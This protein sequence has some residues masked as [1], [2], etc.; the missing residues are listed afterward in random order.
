M[1][2][3]PL[4]RILITS[5]LKNQKTESIVFDNPLPSPTIST[6][7][8]EDQ[9]NESALTPVSE[10]QNEETE[11]KP[12]H[13]IEN[14]TYDYLPQGKIFTYYLYFFYLCYVSVI[15][16]ILAFSNVLSRL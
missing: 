6:L 5:L 7:E 10:V 3:Q 9:I 12:K 8:S 13:I 1:L 4:M 16:P 11:P 2:I 14:V 15:Q